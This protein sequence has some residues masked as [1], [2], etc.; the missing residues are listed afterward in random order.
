[1]GVRGHVVSTLPL[2][3]LVNLLGDVLPE[4]ARAAASRLRFRHVLL[5]FL[6]LKSARISGHASIYIPDPAFC[7]SRIYEP[8][9]RSVEMAPDGETSVVVEA[10]CFRGDA[11]DRL[12]ADGFAERIVA[13]LTSLRLLN[14]RDVL[15]SRHHFIANAYPVYTNGYASDVRLILEALEGIVNLETVGRAGRFLYSHLHDQLRF[16]KDYVRRL[17]DSLRANSA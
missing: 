6:R 16:G 14:P 4:P 2:P 8:R 13:E 1:M 12:P 3:L 10:P 17:T 11:V 5:L 9:N 15:D 7:I